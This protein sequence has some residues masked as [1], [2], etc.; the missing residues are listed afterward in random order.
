MFRYPAARAFAA[1]LTR[2][3]LP[4]DLRV[5]GALGVHCSSQVCSRMRVMH[6]LWRIGPTCR[7][8]FS[9]RPIDF[10][11][12]DFTAHSCRKNE[13]KQSS[14]KSWIELNVRLLGFTPVCGP[15]PAS[16]SRWRND[17]AMSFVL[18]QDC[19][20]VPDTYWVTCI[21]TGSTPPGSSASKSLRRILRGGAFHPLMGLS[22]ATICTSQSARRRYPSACSGADALPRLA[23]S[24]PPAAASCMRFL[25]RP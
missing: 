8:S 11:R 21:Q 23:F 13:S 6:H 18:S 24:S 20:H 4:S 16:F 12:A 15:S 22:P 2:V 7:F 14:G 25:H 19:G 3:V 9:V 5:S 17:P 1:W 10:R